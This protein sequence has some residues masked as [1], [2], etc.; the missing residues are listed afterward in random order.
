M[1]LGITVRS[2]KEFYFV[3]KNYLEY[4]KDFEII[5]L[6]PY[7][8]T[9]AYAQCDGFVVVGGDDVNPKYYNEENIA[10]STVEEEIDKLDLRVIDYAVKHNKPLL[11]ICRGLQITNVYFGG[12]LKQDILNHKNDRHKI[13]AVEE[14][15]NFPNTENVNTF[16]HQSIKKLGNG[17]KAIYYSPDGEIEFITH[18][19]LPIFATQFHP[20]KDGESEFS[21]L[22]LQHFKH[23]LNI[24]K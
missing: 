13:L 3:R 12:S 16:H 2:E 5:F 4:L 18:E 14:F 17:L 23:L 19:K 24:H 8:N 22:I 15:F 11:G 7:L 1:K 9:H 10:S 20:E 6:Y 21:Q